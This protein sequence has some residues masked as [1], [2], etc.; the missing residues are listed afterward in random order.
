MQTV[1]ATDLPDGLHMLTLF[2]WW[3]LYTKGMEFSTRQDGRR[4]VHEPRR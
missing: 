2:Q 4:K 1:L 3:V